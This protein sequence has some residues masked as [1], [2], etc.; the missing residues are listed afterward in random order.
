[1]QVKMIC[2]LT[3]HFLCKHD[4]VQFLCKQA[5]QEYDALVHNDN[6]TLIPPPPGA[7]IVSSNWIFRHKFN[8]DGSLARHKAR[9]VVRGFTQQPGVDFNETFSPVVKHET[10]CIVLSLALSRSWPIHQLDVTYAFLHGN[11]DGEVYS[12]Q[13]SG[14]LD[15]RFP[16]YICHLDKSLYVLKQ[17]P[18]AWFQH[19]IT[20]AHSLGFTESKADSS[21]FIFHHNNS[22]AYLLLYVDDIILTASSSIVLHSIIHQLC[23][24]CSRKDLGPLHH[25]LG[26]SVTRT[27]D[28]LHLSQCQYI[29]D[30]LSWAGKS[31]C[32]PASTPI[33]KKSKLSATT[34]SR[35]SNPFQYRS[36][37]GALQYITPT[38]PEISYVVQ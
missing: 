10:I 13:P 22:T 24:E 5:M 32:N 26:I 16:T 34:G 33:D 3:F 25:F 4:D 11:L 17:A 30:I 38:H 23:I 7:N 21:L 9:W 37:P 14:F 6:W 15:A 35:V 27:S 18:R 1:M 29:L 19:F 31:D 2:V 28:T 8:S 20:Y 36:L 12:Q